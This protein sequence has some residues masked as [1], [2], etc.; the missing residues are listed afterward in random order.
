MTGFPR[1]WYKLTVC[2]QMTMMLLFS[3]IIVC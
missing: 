2:S 1:N 3:R